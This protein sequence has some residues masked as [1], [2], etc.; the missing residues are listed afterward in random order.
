MALLMENREVSA[1]MKHSDWLVGHGEMAQFIRSMDWSATSMGRLEEWPQAVRI[2]TNLVI[3]SG[4]PMAILWSV[5][6]TLVH[7]CLRY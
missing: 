2:V 7:S 3:S 6:W 5:E 4:F 1:T